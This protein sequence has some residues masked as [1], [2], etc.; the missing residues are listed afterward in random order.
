MDPDYLDIILNFLKEIG[1]S[2][3]VKPIEGP[4]FLPGLKIEKGSLVVDVK[5]LLY[6][7]DILH[8]AGH[9]ATMT[10]DVRNEMDDTLPQNDLHQGGEIMAQ[11]WSYAACVH[12]KIDPT[13]VFHENGYKGGGAH[14]IKNFTDGYDVG[15]PLLQY[16]GMAYEKKKA[17]ELNTPG[18]PHMVKWLREQ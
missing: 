15:L 7:G 14:I 1:L 2:V 16:A 8:E 3:I 17:V 13:I 6:P 12:L 10:P 4:T 5:K 18:F 11:A 9:L